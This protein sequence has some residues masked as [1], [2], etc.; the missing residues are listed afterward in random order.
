MEPLLQTYQAAME[1]VHGLSDWLADVYLRQLPAVSQGA[2]PPSQEALAQRQSL[3]KVLSL[4]AALGTSH[5]VEL[6]PGVINMV[7]KALIRMLD[8]A[9]SL[10]T[11]PGFWTASF[12]GQSLVASMLS[13][14]DRCLGELFVS[15]PGAPHPPLSTALLDRVRVS[16]SKLT[17]RSG[18]CATGEGGAKQVK[19][20]RF[21][22]GHVA[23]IVRN[24]P[25]TLA[26]G[27]TM[28][29]ALALFARIKCLIPPCR[30]CYPLHQRLAVGVR[31]ELSSHASPYVDAILY[32]LL[33][34]AQ[35]EP[36]SRAAL[37]QELCLVQPSNQR[38]EPALPHPAAAMG[39][40]EE[41]RVVDDAA[42]RL[43]L[44]Q[45][46]LL[47]VGTYSQDVQEAFVACV[48]TLLE[49]LQTAAPHCLRL[50][51]LAAV[52]PED[53]EDAEDA[54]KRDYATGREQ[55]EEADLLFRCLSMLGGLL[56]AVSARLR[57]QALRMLVAQVQACL[58]SCGRSAHGL[59][60]GLHADV[61]KPRQSRRCGRG[62][63][64]VTGTHVVQVITG[65][66]GELAQDVAVHVWG[67]QLRRV[68]PPAAVAQ[69][70]QQ[71]LMLLGEAQCR[72]VMPYS[73]LQGQLA[74]LVVT[75]LPAAPQDA[76]VRVR[77][78]LQPAH[79]LG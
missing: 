51:T 1:C 23:S 77:S 58:D 43:V 32:S 44:V 30:P 34:T 4:F 38:S 52:G 33:T 60:A 63:Q 20:I 37:I 45:S 46:A 59:L 41:A 62:A 7:F 29:G 48:P 39:T 57:S 76:V 8:A 50:Q 11:P 74:F 61:K 15:P 5:T 24:A 21:M 31:S 73:R 19:L 64:T 49:L 68:L 12:D 17:A 14:A 67:V 13:V 72:G 10:T 78:L 79:A 36:A 75:A 65:G 25:H 9:G 42:G 71:L 27:E 54:R 6:R 2:E 3:G 53:A 16:R 70:V 47:H 69:H 66:T 26:P 18:A 22:L 55:E 56:S 28:A 35:L 40:D